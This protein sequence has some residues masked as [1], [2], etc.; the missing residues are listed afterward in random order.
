M[1]RLNFP[2][3][4]LRVKDSERGRLIFD[5][6]RKKYIALTPEEWV[7]QHCLHYLLNDKHYPRSRTVVEHTHRVGGL[8]RRS[9]IVVFDRALNPFILVECK[10]YKVSINQNT[11]DQINRYNFIMKAPY[12]FVSNGL[13]H[14]F[15]NIDHQL[16][17]VGWLKDLPQYGH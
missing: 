4:P 3:Y 5:M 13:K 17:K 1:Q 6:V 9:D 2:D 8:Y 10:S 14:V 16:K 7:R 11:F 15:C 12:L